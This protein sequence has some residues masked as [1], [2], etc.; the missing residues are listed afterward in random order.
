MVLS[1]A[2]E[3]MTNPPKP[4]RPSDAS[5]LGSSGAARRLVVLGTGGTIAGQAREAGD[6]VGYTSGQVGVH[7]LL[8]GVQALAAHVPALSGWDLEAEQ[9]AQVDSKDMG[10]TVWR[11][12]MV[13]VAHHLARPEVAGVVVTHGT[14]TLEETAWLLQAVL[15]PT[16]PVVLT[17]AMRPATAL[18]PDGPQNLM[19]ALCVAASPG[20]RGVVAVCAGLVHQAHHV[21]KVHTYRLNAFDSGDAGPLGCVEEGRLRLWQDWPQSEAHGP[22]LERLLSQVAW[23]RVEVIVS[24]AGAD[25]ALVRALLAAAGAGEPLRGLVVAG[26]GNGTVHADLL[27]ALHQAQAVGVVVWRGTRCA[28]GQ[29]V[30]GPHETL[31]DTAGLSPVKARLSL[32][33]ALLAVGA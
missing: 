4:S 23:P 15:G 24:H 18:V 29:V 20:A 31:P 12:L 5:A 9:V 1:A 2:G 26:T 33:L 10:P 11:A 22:L 30:A 14:D 6:N 3:H 27:D 7:Q 25:G 32:M 16:K 8:E 21:Q 19:D 28:Y 13:R 17:C